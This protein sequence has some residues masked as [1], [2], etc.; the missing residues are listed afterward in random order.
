LYEVEI[1]ESQRKSEVI[2]YMIDFKRTY[3]QI[4]IALDMKI[5]MEDKARS[6]N[7]KLKTRFAQD[8]S[9]AM[10]Y[11]QSMS[12]KDVECIVEK[13]TKIVGNFASKEDAFNYRNKLAIE[14]AL[15]D[16]Q[17]Y[18]KRN[19]EKTEVEIRDVNISQIST[20][21]DKLIKEYVTYLGGVSYEL[22]ITSDKLFDQSVDNFC[23]K[24]SKYLEC[25][26]GYI[27]NHG[28][29]KNK[30][31]LR[32]GGLNR[33]TVIDVYDVQTQDNIWYLLTTGEFSN[34]DESFDFCNSIG[35]TDS[36]CIVYERSLS[37]SILRRN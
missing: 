27:T 8:A 20:G 14:G 35:I 12:D 2:S 4:F 36:K 26:S 10:E 22:L 7:Y 28:I 30:L 3:P 1:A 37:S 16:K 11:C 32:R 17:V 9:K 19:E 24:Y 13:E 31:D 25:E 18:I 23:K 33:N 29:E 34:V 6:Y 5:R 21:K 15:A